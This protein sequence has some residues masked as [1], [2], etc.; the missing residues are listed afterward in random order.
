MRN[1][2]ALLNESGDVRARVVA[3]MRRVGVHVQRVHVD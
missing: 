3:N 1:G 2:N